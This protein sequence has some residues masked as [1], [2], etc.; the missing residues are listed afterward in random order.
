MASTIEKASRG[1]SET[2]REKV[3]FGIINGLSSSPPRTKMKRTS[4]P[5]EDPSPSP[6]QDGGGK[7]TKTG[8]SSGA[9]SVRSSSFVVIGLAGGIA[10]GK[11]TVI[12][13][14][15]GL[16]AVV[17]DA[18]KFG[19][20]VY[21]K[22]TACF[23]EMVAGFGKGIVGGD[24]EVDRKVLGPIVFGDKAKMDLLCS[25]T[26]PVIRTR[27]QAAVDEH[28]AAG[29]KVVVIEAAILLEAGWE[30]MMDSV[31]VLC[32]DPATA[33]ERVMARNSLAWEAAQARVDA[34]MKNDERIAKAG[35]AATVLWNDGSVEELAE[36]VKQ[37]YGKD[38][39]RLAAAL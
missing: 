31:W 29:A 28:R 35:A 11:S 39:E 33:V 24:G 1:K 3:G 25:I 14:V 12:K 23:D 26:W 38:L 27:L 21:A 22:G 2:V 15:D 37:A 18:D 6:P 19:H 36:K 5:G 32:V 7:A 34:Q 13:V 16:G 9:G 20:G 8:D 30:D 10:S 4:S 17:L